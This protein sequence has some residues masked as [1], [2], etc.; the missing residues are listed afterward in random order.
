M[1]ILTHYT[2]GLIGLETFKRMKLRL[3]KRLILT[4]MPLVLLVSITA[5]PEKTPSSSEPG[6]IAICWFVQ[7]KRSVLVA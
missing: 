6:K 4:N 3:V 5:D 2:V 1:K 7:V